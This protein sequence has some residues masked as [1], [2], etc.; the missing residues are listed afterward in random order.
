M[1]TGTP[2][3]SGI[4]SSTV[5]GMLAPPGTLGSFGSLN[6][7]EKGNVNGQGQGFAI[8]SVR[9][10]GK[11]D[12]KKEK[13]SK[14]G[15]EVEK[16]KAQPLRHSTSTFKAGTLT[17]SLDGLSPVAG[18]FLGPSSGASANANAKTFGVKKSSGMP[19]G[20][21]L[22]STMRLPSSASMGVG[23][24]PSSVGPSVPGLAPFPIITSAVKTNLN[25]TNADTNPLNTI[26]DSRL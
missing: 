2:S 13:A 1:R 4:L 14:Q 20:L 19:L 6:G 21:R 10:L 24:S 23:S 8:K 18:E 16:G 12:S 17:S 9:S 7:G 15:K 22:P 26:A 3:R 11:E 5:G 25:D